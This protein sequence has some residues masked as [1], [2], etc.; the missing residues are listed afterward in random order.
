MKPP[1]GR[2]Q[3]TTFPRMQLSLAPVCHGSV[4]DQAFPTERLLHPPFANTS[5]Q[6][7]Q[8]T[9]Y[10]NHQARALSRLFSSSTTS[11]RQ[12]RAA[13]A[14]ARSANIVTQRLTAQM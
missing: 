4:P 8:R 14:I 1:G 12:L 11:R 13:K 3:L 6:D 5:C 9:T 2:F 7:R 10:R